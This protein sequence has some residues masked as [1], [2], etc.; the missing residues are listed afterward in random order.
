MSCG[1]KDYV[2]GG[3]VL[4]YFKLCSLLYKNWNCGIVLYYKRVVLKLIICEGKFDCYNKYFFL[5]V[6]LVMFLLFINLG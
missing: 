4:F 1:V 5:M 6:V 2:C 3:D